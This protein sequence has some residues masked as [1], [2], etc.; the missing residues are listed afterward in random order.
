M[1][2]GLLL[3]RKDLRLLV[4]SPLLLVVLVGYPLL[5]SLLVAAALQSEDRPPT[6]AVVVL[7]TP[8]RTIQVGDRR[9]G[10][11]DYIDRLDDEVE[12]R[13]LGPEAAERELAAGR[14]AAILTVP[15]GFIRDLQSGVRQPTLRLVTS[16]R[17]PI[18]GEAITRRLEAAVFR[19]NQGLATGYVRQVVAL[20]DFITNGGSIGVFG[21]EGDVIGLRASRVL[22]ADAQRRLR[23][24][25]RG[26]LADRLDPLLVFI[27]ETQANLDLVRPAATAI[28]SPIR[29]DT[30]EGAQGREPLSAF[31]VAA[32]LLVSIA[33]A[34][35]LLA[36]SG[37]AAEREEGTLVRLRRGL[38]PAWVVVLVKVLVAAL[39]A[40]LI[41][42]V[43]LGA[44]AVLTD[45]EVGRWARWLPVLLS[46]GAAFGAF[47]A[48]VGA[49]ARE[50]RTALLATLM[51]SLP[52]LFV[53]LIPGRVPDAVASVVPF[54]PG[55]DA[56][57]TLLAESEVGAG[58]LRDA[59]VLVVMTAVLVTAS[60]LLLRRRLAD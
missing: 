45:L 44:V 5:V 33:L 18:E 34:A 6:L 21:R 49:A 50:T 9:L 41:G 27:D 36:A 13:R 8:G 57:R 7:D 3:L 19:F 17:S 4:R 29:L 14:V 38:A 46:A 56:F 15:A 54:G 51:L 35:G 58:P 26:T 52:L 32:A 11:D 55:F 23:A 59:A 42:L 53:G 16:A 12:V 31:G 24:D 10:V 25:G 40:L 1:R 28:S 22:I 20:A 43:L 47:G 39:V 30:G 48:L 37:I 2:A 60:T